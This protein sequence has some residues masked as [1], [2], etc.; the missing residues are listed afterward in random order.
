M[1]A[2]PTSKDGLLFYLENLY[3]FFQVVVVGG[4]HY[5]TPSS[6]H[7]FT[8]SFTS[9]WTFGNLGNGGE[10]PYEKTRAARQKFEFDSL[11]RLMWMLLELH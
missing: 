10:L 9:C 6:L 4:F 1:V 5:I 2:V 11:R 8:P 3:F 7:S